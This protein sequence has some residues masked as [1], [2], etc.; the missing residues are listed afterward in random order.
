[1]KKLY[2]LNNSEGCLFTKQEVDILVKFRR[3]H[4][5]LAIK[6]LFTLFAACHGVNTLV[7]DFATFE[8]LVNYDSN[9]KTLLAGNIIVFSGRFKAI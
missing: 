3:K 9:F 6:P 5:K 7:N 2:Q 1:M 4:S 8:A